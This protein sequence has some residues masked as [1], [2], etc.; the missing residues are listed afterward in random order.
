MDLLKVI[1]H[2]DKVVIKTPQGQ[3]RKGKAVMYNRQYNSWVL[4][5]GGAHGTPGIASEKNIVSVNGKPLPQEEGI[6]PEGEGHKYN[7]WYNDS[8]EEKGVQKVEVR[9]KSLGEATRRGKSKKFL[10][11]V[12]LAEGGFKINESDLPSG[13][14]KIGRA[15]CRERV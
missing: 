6:E 10:R 4:N 8:P 12:E 3:E 11:R 15:S 9:A 14:R 2:G 5:M 1:R 13:V 7:L